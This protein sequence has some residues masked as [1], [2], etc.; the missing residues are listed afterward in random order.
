MKRLSKKSKVSK[1]VNPFKRIRLSVAYRSDIAKVSNE[2]AERYKV[3]YSA[4]RNLVTV[5]N[6]NA[7]LGRKSDKIVQPVMLQL[8]KALGDKIDLEIADLNKRV[9]DM[10][11][12]SAKDRQTVPA[13]DMSR[14]IALL[15]DPA[16]MARLMAKAA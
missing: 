7:T 16:V 8:L 5:Y 10:D 2:N 11:I 9:A 1:Q 4:L 12:V 14:V 13:I 3:A 6:V 15:S